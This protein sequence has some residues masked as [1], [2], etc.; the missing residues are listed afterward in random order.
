VTGTKRLAQEAFRRGAELVVVDT[1]GLVQ[2]RLGRQLKQAKLDLLQP[3]L[4]LAVE[5]GDELEG[6]L[7]L[8]ETGST[9]EVIRLRPH[10]A[11]RVKPAAL[12][13]ARRA[14][15]F[16]RHFTG[17]RTFEL[18]SAQVALSHTWLFT[19]RPVAPHQLRVA[20]SALRTEIIY[21]E[22]TEDAV[23]LLARGQRAA[24]VPSEVRQEFRRPVVVT[25]A[26]A[27]QNLLV[28]LV[29]Q[30][31]NVADVGILQGVHFQ[32]R[33]LT[34]LTPLDHVGMIRQVRLGRLRL[35]PDGSEIGHLKPGDL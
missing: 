17:A 1:S 34:V 29:E 21:G 23:H 3:E 10:P 30:D 14:G 4:V 26:Y 15:R 16:Y 20:A 24:P 31:G 22:E 5:R 33:L 18:P 32:R 7:R 25:P 8:V 9:A 6:V 27:L 28:G 11:A 19:G 13:R 35:R 12:R 2:G